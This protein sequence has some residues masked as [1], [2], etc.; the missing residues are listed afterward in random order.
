M[1]EI[2]GMSNVLISCI[3][4]FVLF[5]ALCC[6]GVLIY[7]LIKYEYDKAMQEYENQEDNY[8]KPKS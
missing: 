3:L 6:I 1:E 8:A 4:V 5:G 7:K 2:E